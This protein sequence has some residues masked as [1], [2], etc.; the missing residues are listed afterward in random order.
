LSFK[1]KLETMPIYASN[2][3][4]DLIRA[5]GVEEQT[6]CNSSMVGW[7]RGIWERVTKVLRVHFFWYV[8]SSN[9]HTSWMQSGGDFLAVKIYVDFLVYNIM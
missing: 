2:N 7:D 3:S 5:R 8:F 4:T 1:T 9:V 6:T